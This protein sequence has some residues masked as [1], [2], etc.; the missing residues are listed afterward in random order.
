MIAYMDSSALVKRAETG[1]DSELAADLWGSADRIVSSELACSE[2]R[3]AIG[4]PQEILADLEIVEM[5]GQIADAADELAKRH[6]LDTSES[7]HLAAALSIDAPRV[8]VATWN[9]ALAT[10]AAECGLAVV[11]R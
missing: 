5:D 2:A 8:V 9:P 4:M 10:A 7:V 6:S 3:A 1:P 11:P